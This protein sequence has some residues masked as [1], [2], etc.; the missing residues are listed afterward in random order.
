ML[1]TTIMKNL[2]VAS[3]VKETK[4]RKDTYVEER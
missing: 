3:L 4:G 1:E 2:Y